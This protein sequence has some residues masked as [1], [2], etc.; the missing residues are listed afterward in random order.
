MSEVEQVSRPLLE[1]KGL[2]KYFPIQQ[3]ILRRTVGWIK[4]V[5]GVDLEIGR[6][7]TL[8]VVGESGSGKTTIARIVAGLLEATEGSV[9]FSGGGNEVDVTTLDAKAKKLARRH[10]QMIF[11][12]P[13]SSLNARMPILEIVGEPLIAHGIARGQALKDQVAPLLQSVGLQPKHMNLYPHEMSGGQR[14]RIGLARALALNPELVICDEPVSA[15]DVSVQAQILN[16]LL[17]MQQ[18]RGLSYLFIAHS[19]SV[20]AW[21]SDRIA[22]MYLGRVVEIS[23]GIDLYERPLHP[24]TEILLW[25][26]PVP[27]PTVARERRVLTGEIPSPANPPPGCPFHTRCPHAE[28]RCKVE[29]PELEEVEE[30]HFVSCLR[31]R[32]LSLTGKPIWNSQ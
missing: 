9:M 23:S 21:M 10:M 17:E 18:S 12:D 8:G 14:Q 7:E 1:V 28:D 16:L 5:D 24:Y 15:L 3:G 13:Y 22:V 29:V 30:G 25:N 4:A 20:V 6:A 26:Y 32:D 11:Q 2:K 31:W 27:D 19:L